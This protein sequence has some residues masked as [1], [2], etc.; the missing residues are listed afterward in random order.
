MLYVFWYL[1]SYEEYKSAMILDQWNLVI[2]SDYAT[3]FCERLARPELKT[4][5]NLVSR[6]ILCYPDTMSSYIPTAKRMFPQENIRKI[7]EERLIHIGQCKIWVQKTISNT[8]IDDLL[9]SLE[10]NNNGIC[11]SNWTQPDKSQFSPIS[12]KYRREEEL[13][14]IVYDKT[15]IPSWFSKKTFF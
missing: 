2:P 15:V 1:H 9:Y 12:S 5:C 3:D 11:P 10:S 13:Q 7:V 6:I 14:S 8:F 4:I